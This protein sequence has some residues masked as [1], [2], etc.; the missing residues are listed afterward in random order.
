MKDEEGDA[1]G[2]HGTMQ[3]KGR[4]LENRSGSWQT[5]ADGKE[6]LMLESPTPLSKRVCV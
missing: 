6:K 1:L 4:G 3:K 5:D 2:T